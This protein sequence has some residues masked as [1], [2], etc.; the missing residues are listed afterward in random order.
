M[1]RFIILSA[2]TVTFTVSARATVQGDN[3]EIQWFFPDTGTVFTSNS[4]VAVPGL[5]DTHSQVLI[6][7]QDGQII[8]TNNTLGWQASGGFN[9][10]V[11]TDTSEVPN[12]SSFSLV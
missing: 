10:F 1:K 8:I 5:W 7:I 9:G 3:F 12:F 4:S 6:N 2:L 11:F